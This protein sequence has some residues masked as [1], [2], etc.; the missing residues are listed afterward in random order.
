MRAKKELNFGIQFMSPSASTVRC[1]DV[2]KS[3]GWYQTEEGRDK[4]FS[5]VTKAYPNF[6]FRV[7]TKDRRPALRVVG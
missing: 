1:R 5:R 2:W 3:W 6:Q 7:I 4:A